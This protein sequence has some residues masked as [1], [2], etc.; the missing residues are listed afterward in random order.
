MWILWI[1]VSATVLIV[2][3]IWAVFL[4]A[5]RRALVGWRLLSASGLALSV[6][7]FNFVI[8]FWKPTAG[9]YRVNELYPYGS[10]LHAWAV[11]F[12]FAWIAFGFLFAGLALLGSRSASRVVWVTLLTSWLICWLPHGV[13]VLAFAWAGQNA[14]NVHSYRQW[15]S[16]LAGF[17][18]LLANALMLLA[19]FGFSLGGFIL[20]ARELWWERVKS[21]EVV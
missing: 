4:P 7:G 12:G 19:H 18:L 6:M 1:T 14:Q 20:S 3:C 8:R 16:D 10:Y 15:A 5:F 2:L 9:P 11:S 13:I 17:S 21:P